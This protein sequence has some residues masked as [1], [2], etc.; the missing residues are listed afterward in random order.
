MTRAAINGISPFFIGRNVAAAVAFYRDKLGFEV[1]YQEPKDD[2]FFAIVCRGGAMLMVKSVE[3]S[4]APNPTRDPRRSGM[5]M[6]ACPILKRWRRS[7]R[8][9]VWCFR[10][11]EGHNGRPAWIRVERH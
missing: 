1:S 4:P 8:R 5:L 6:S 9:A 2:P 10:T 7:S 11:A 3:A